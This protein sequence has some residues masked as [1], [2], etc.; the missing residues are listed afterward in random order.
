K[1]ILIIEYRA[2]QT[3]EAI[4]KA[5]KLIQ[6]LQKKNLGYAH[7]IVQSPATAQVWARRKAGLGLLSNVKGDKKPVACIEDT[8]VDI[9]DLPDYIDEFETMLSSFGQKAVY[10]AHAGAGELHLRPMLN[11]KAPADRQ[12]FHD[13]SEATAKLVKKYGGSLS[14][15]HGDGRVRAPFLERMIGPRNYRL[16]ED[17]KGTWD[18]LGI[19][20]PGKIINP[21]PITQD[22][23]YEADPKEFTFSTFF[24]WSADGSI[25]LATERCTGSGDCRKLPLSGGTMCPSYRATRNEKDSTRGRANIL[26]EC[27]TQSQEDNPFDSADLKEAL[28]LCLSCKACATE[29]PSTV[30]MT[31]MKAEF[32]YQYHKKHGIPRRTRAI[33]NLT[34]I[35]R[36]GIT[37]P[38]LTNA[39]TQ[40]KWGSHLIKKYLSVASERSLPRLSPFSLTAWYRRK[41]KRLTSKGP[42]KGN[43]FLYIDE[44]TNYQDAKMGRDAILLLTTLGYQVHVANLNQSGRVHL[45]KGLLEE[46]RTFAEYNVKA[47]A[48]V[49]SSDTPLVGLEPSAILSFRDE[50]PRLVRSHLKKDAQRIAP[51]ALTFED[52]FYQEFQKGK[53]NPYVFTEDQA[54][55]LVHSHCHQKAIDGPESTIFCLSIPRNYNVSFIP[56]GCCGMAGSFGYE[57]EH[58][59]L[60][61]VIGEQTLFPA[62]REAAPDTILAAS[63]TSCRHQ[64][65]DGTQRTALHPAQILYQA[66]RPTKGI[67]PGKERNQ[68]PT[69]SYPAQTP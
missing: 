62:V 6:I 25:L 41:K 35:N 38:W 56:A 48:Q 44:F 58:Y 43:V 61:Q 67:D 57:K 37:A 49:L 23:R 4:K 34:E 27:L 26:R 39:V 55:V 22:L 65:K 8:A 17:I 69:H 64:I 66:L 15:E 68:I 24:D 30:D 33:A 9:R 51:L 52:F 18:P 7:P 53:I 19:F 60:S 50:Y 36:M 42:I 5:E 47:M 14:G 13:I 20:N 59:E 28:D 1:A 2:Y 11:L 31:A 54:T 16:M 46:A 10:Y 21:K 32:Q 12:L 3:D 45:S 63:G 40:S 29:C